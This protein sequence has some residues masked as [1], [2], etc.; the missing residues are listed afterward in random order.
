MIK[1]LTNEEFNVLNKITAKAKMDW[2]VI[3]DDCIIDIEEDKAL[4]FEEGILLVDS[5]LTSLDDYNLTEDEKSCYINLIYKIKMQQKMPLERVSVLLYNALCLLE[6]DYGA[7]MG[8]DI[9]EEL[10]ITQEE[11]DWIMK[12]DNG[13]I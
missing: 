12:S 4:S 5:G 13:R 9:E 7:I 6:D 11:Y 8:T 10:G 2:C 3:Y 1:E